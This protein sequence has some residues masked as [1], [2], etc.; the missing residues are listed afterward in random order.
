DTLEAILLKLEREL[1]KNKLKK[2]TGSFASG[3]PRETVLRS[4]D[5]LLRSLER[6]REDCGVLLAC[7]LQR[8]MLPMVDRYS[9][10]K[11]QSGKLDFLDLL[12]E[13]AKLLRSNAP[14]RSYFQN[15]F[16]HIFVDEFQD[17]DPLQA[18]VLLLLSAFDPSISDWQQVTP[19]PGKLFLVG[20]PK[21]SVYKFRRADVQLYRR[22][23]DNLVGRGVARVSLTTSY[24]AVL[25]IQQ[26]V[27]AA[28]SRCMDAGEEHAQAA[29]SPLDESGPQIPGQPAVVALPVPAPYGDFRDVTKKA[30]NES[31][32]AATAA[33]ID[34]LL[35]ES[36]WKVR[37][38]G[39]LVPIASR[40][41]C[42][43][44]RRF[45]QYR[46]DITRPYVKGLETRGI[47]H[48]LVGSRTFHHREEIEAVRTALTAIEWPEDEL[49]VFAALKGSLFAIS[50][51]LL[52]R[53]R[54]ETGGALHPFRKLGETAGEFDCIR[55]ALRLLGSLHRER[56]RRPVADTINA[57]LEHVRAHAGFALRPG[58]QQVLA[59]VHRL[60]DLARGFESSGGVSFRAFIGELEAQAEKDETPEAPVLEEASEGVR[61]MTV[62]NAKGLEFPIVILA[63]VTANICRQEP[64]RYI[65]ATRSLCAT[66][67]LFCSPRELL[68]N[69][70]VE[71]SR[72]EAEGVRVCYVA[73]TRAKDLLVVPAVGDQPFEGWLSPLNSALYPAKDAWRRPDSCSYLSFAGRTTVLTRPHVV[74]EHQEYSVMPGLHAAGCGVHQVLWHDPAT[75]DLDTEETFGMPHISILKNEGASVQSLAS[76]NAWASERQRTLAQASTKS[77]DPFLPV[78]LGEAPRH[79]KVDRENIRSRDASVSGRSFGTLVH[80]VLRDVSPNAARDEI[81][82]HARLQGLI[83]GAGPSEQDAAVAVVERVL[84]HPLWKTAVGSSEMLRELPV[85][86]R[87]DGSRM[88]DGVLDLAYMSNE[89]W[90]VVDYKTDVDI[91]ARLDEYENQLRWY[92]HA[93]SS[94]TGH[95]ARG[96]LLQL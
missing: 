58:G 15:R 18:E 60:C 16:T 25:G 65:D 88:L 54:I 61:L 2:G 75:L 12:Y 77:L 59:N 68:E 69:Q 94:L 71:R 78:E 55:D 49:A 73:A 51:E 34:W 72:E 11:A 90:V 28:F 42:I 53:F 41:I 1:K 48:L 20:D 19:A 21:Q 67:L 87:L 56:N 45:L 64:E 50:D 27:N 80:A 36:R 84:A 26:F 10:L 86:L 57:L 47:P 66:Q 79:Y 3:L 92:L 63:D 33:Y 35:N 76:W 52:F 74:L 96:V 32:P 46:E 22:I 81:V 9:R 85:S 4:Y 38:N 24:R 7:Q 23:S 95:P 91:D 8:E 82:S 43:L 17:T 93:L 62:H 31:L 5:E 39:D 37:E 83:V 44:F 29:Y 14:V 6:F 40:H 70:V 89:G 13:A 30:I